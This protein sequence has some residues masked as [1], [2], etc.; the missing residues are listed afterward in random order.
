MQNKQDSRDRA[1]T[2]LRDLVDKAMTWFARKRFQGQGRERLHYTNS[3]LG[4]AI[5]RSNMDFWYGLCWYKLNAHKENIF[6][7]KH[8]KIIPLYH[9][10]ENNP[11][12]ILNPKE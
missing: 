11:V 3:P 5:G 9:F 1:D 7:R 10:T 6:I 2:L 4:E 12:L 8:T